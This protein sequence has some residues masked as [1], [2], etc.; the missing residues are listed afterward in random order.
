MG[1]EAARLRNHVQRDLRRPSLDLRRILPTELSLRHLKAGA[2]RC[3]PGDCDRSG[4]DIG[5]TLDEVGRT[6]T[7]LLPGEF[8]GP[9]SG[10]PHE[11]GQTDSTTEQ[12]QFIRRLQPTRGI[13]LV[14]GETRL[15][16]RRPEAVARSCERRIHRGRPQ[17]RVDADD[18]QLQP[19]GI[20]RQNIVDRIRV[21]RGESREIVLGRFATAQ[22]GWPT[23]ADEVVLTHIFHTT[24]GP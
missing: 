17:P 16:Q 13:D 1:V 9:D 21:V 20:G 7:Q 23:I 2:E 6:F 4:P 8:V 15:V 5:K 18:E 24:V 3:D 12:L 11:V 10:S 14:I 19:G 22:R